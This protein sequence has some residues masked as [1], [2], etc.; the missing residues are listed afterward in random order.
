MHVATHDPKVSSLQL[1]KSGLSA[2]AVDISYRMQADEVR[3]SDEE[4]KNVSVGWVLVTYD[5]DEYCT[6]QNC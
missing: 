4:G 2:E 3:A 6:T 5:G 1:H